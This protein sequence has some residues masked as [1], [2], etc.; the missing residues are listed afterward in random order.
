MGNSPTT[1]SFISV[2]LWLRAPLNSGARAAN[3]RFTDNLYLAGHCKHCRHRRF[4]LKGTIL[5]LATVSK[6]IMHWYKDQRGE[7]KW[8]TKNARSQE[9][10]IQS[11]ECWTRC[12]VGELILWGTKGWILCLVQGVQEQEGDLYVWNERNG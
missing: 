12:K 2:L 4:R 3:S 1:N 9:R 5:K 10:I 7:E 11:F 8:T 6:C